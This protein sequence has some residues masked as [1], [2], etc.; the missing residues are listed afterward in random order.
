MGRSCLSNR[1]RRGGLGGL[2]AGSAKL[3]DEACQGGAGLAEFSEH[4]MARSH[5]TAEP[6][7]AGKHT[8]Q[9]CQ[10][11]RELEVE[12]TGCDQCE[13]TDHRRAR[14]HEAW[15][16][17]IHQFPPLEG[18]PAADI[19]DRDGCLEWEAYELAER[20][21]GEPED[22]GP[23]KHGRCRGTADGTCNESIPVGAY[24][25]ENRERQ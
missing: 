18:Y 16:E 7:K 14:H 2:A 12:S 21:R 11:D 5:Q 10:R 4:R 15:H 23:A 13:R 25:G 9:G 22:A 24:G 20:D 6:A 1:W 3:R 17:G 19:V 8:S